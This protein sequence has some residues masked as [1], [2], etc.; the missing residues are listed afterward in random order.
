[1]ATVPEMRFPSFPQRA[2]TG[3]GRHP[4]AHGGESLTTAGL[5]LLWVFLE[6]NLLHMVTHSLLSMSPQIVLEGPPA[7]VTL[8][9]GRGSEWKEK[10]PMPP[11][12][13]TV[14]GLVCKPCTST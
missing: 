3:T 12:F 14:T 6:K 2:R 10:H 13:C 1:M 11:S 7:L 8:G 4:W 9:T 5:S